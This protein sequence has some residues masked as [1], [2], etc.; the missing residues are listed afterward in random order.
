MIRN[1]PAS[2]I[3]TKLV[4]LH[5]HLSSGVIDIVLCPFSPFPDFLTCPA[6]VLGS[7]Y[8]C[9]ATLAYCH[10][11]SSPCSPTFSVCSPVPPCARVK[12]DNPKQT[13]PN[14]C[15]NRPAQRPENWPAWDNK[16]SVS[17]ASP[18]RN[19]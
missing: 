12:D 6:L 5:A 2:I 15:H 10:Y 14:L 18:S 11:L 7:C 13:L 1:T 19:R 17:L 9:L 3:V 8:Q 4:K 16:R